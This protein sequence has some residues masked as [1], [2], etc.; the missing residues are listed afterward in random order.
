[1][2]DVDFKVG[3]VIQQKDIL[4]KILSF[5]DSGLEVEFISC[6]WDILL[7]YIDIGKRYS[8]KKLDWLTF[9]ANFP[10]AWHELDKAKFLTDTANC[11]DR[12]TADGKGQYIAAAIQT[13][14]GR[15][16]IAKAMLEPI[17]RQRDIS[18]EKND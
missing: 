1:M 8:L 7:R 5:N 14:Y 17:K 12:S 15:K 3:S 11:K 10:E 2:E 4:F 13:E 9:K 16:M 18:N 6:G